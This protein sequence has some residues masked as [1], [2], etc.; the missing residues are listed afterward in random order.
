MPHDLGENM[1]QSLSEFVSRY[2]DM[3]DHAEHTSI[4]KE[5]TL[6]PVNPQAVLVTSHHQKRLESFFEI[7]SHMFFTDL[8]W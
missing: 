1:L 2:G 8:H 4:I 5:F 3:L 7:H 6:S